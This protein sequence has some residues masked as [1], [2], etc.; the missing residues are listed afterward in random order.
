MVSYFYNANYNASQYD[1][2]ESL[3]H[4]QVATIADKYDCASL[5]KLARTSFANAVNAIEKDDWITVA[6]FVYHHTI[7]EWLPHQNL[8]DLVIA[9]VADRP[10]VL[11]SILLLNGPYASKTEGAGGV[12][13]QVR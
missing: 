11:K 8:R 9:T 2:S 12:S 7:I 6:A 10:S 4:A 5:C 3:L 1:M 13:K